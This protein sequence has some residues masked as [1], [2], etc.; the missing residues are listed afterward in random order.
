MITI[1][2][3]KK[4]FEILLDIVRTLNNNASFQKTHDSKLHFTR[5]YGCVQDNALVIIVAANES[6]IGIACNNVCS[7]ESL[8]IHFFNLI[9]G[10]EPIRCPSREETK[11]REKDAYKNTM[12]E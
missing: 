12:G 3:S 2:Y 1:P 11:P 5:C 9:V 8:Y 7:D 6:N 4:S 10:A